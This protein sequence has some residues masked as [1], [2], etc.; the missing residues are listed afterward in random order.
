MLLLAE[1]E[2]M[3]RRRLRR[4]SSIDREIPVGHPA[5]V[6]QK[7]SYK[8]REHLDRNTTATDAP[9]YR[10]SIRCESVPQSC[11]MVRETPKNNQ[12]LEALATAAYLRESIEQRGADA[13]TFVGEKEPVDDEQVVARV[14]T[15]ESNRALQYGAW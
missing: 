11:E 14:A 10:A 12:L 3:Q 4:H 13:E 5:V 7:Y 15:C 9:R 8:R 2:R 6:C 1:S